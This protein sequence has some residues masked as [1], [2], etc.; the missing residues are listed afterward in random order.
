MV[1]GFVRPLLP[2]VA[3]PPPGFLRPFGPCRQHGAVLGVEA[4]V[5]RVQWHVRASKPW[6][7]W[8]LFLR[9]SALLFSFFLF[10]LFFLLFFHFLFLFL[11]L[12]FFLFFFHILLF[13]LLLHRT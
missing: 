1:L 11:F 6:A 4:T 2:H 7:A 9:L 3:L 10:L 12:L 13:H 5:G 8:L